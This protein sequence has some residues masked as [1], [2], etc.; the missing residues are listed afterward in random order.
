MNL[1]KENLVNHPFFSSPAEEQQFAMLWNGSARKLSFY[2]GLGHT[3]RDL[4]TAQ[5]LA[6]VANLLWN[7]YY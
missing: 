1:L 7:A 2:N 5:K 6:S 3:Q 4:G